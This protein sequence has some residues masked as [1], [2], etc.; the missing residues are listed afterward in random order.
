MTIS[1][2]REALPV[3]LM[4]VIEGYLQHDDSIVEVGTGPDGDYEI[5]LSGGEFGRR[6]ITARRWPAVR[7]GWLAVSGPHGDD[8]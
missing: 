3:G 5:E 8:L 1:E 4:P 7:Y 2:L 6:V